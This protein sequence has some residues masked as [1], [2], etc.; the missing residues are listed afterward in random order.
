MKI[1][2]I[3]LALATPL[4]AADGLLPG[5]PREKA[6]KNGCLIHCLAAVSKLEQA[7]IK[8]RILTFF[9]RGRNGHAIAVFYLDGETYV[10]DPAAGTAKVA[11]TRITAPKSVLSSISWLKGPMDSPAYF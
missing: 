7:G 5:A 6:I 9:R 4:C 10:Y 11:P 3:I 2:A 1:I 8:A